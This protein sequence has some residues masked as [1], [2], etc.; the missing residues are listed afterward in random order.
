MNA[1]VWRIAGFGLFALGMVGIVVPVMPTTVFWILAALCFARSSPRMYRRIVTWPNVGPT[2]SLFLEH[3]AIGRRSKVVAVG[4]IATGAG[5]LWLAHPGRTLLIAAGAIFLGST[6]YILTRPSRPCAIV[7]L[8]PPQAG[9]DDP[10]A[11]N[12]GSLGG[13]DG[14]A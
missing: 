8:A 1:L 13:G 2:V 5:L 11:A 3:G 14:A 9:A 6:L 4:G 7:H 12:R 10:G